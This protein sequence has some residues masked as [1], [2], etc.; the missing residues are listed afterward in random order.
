[1]LLEKPLNFR[2][3]KSTVVMIFLP[4]MIFVMR[5]FLH[6]I[7]MIGMHPSGYHNGH[8]FLPLSE[9]M[10]YSGENH[11]HMVPCNLPVRPSWSHLNHGGAEGW[12]D[13]IDT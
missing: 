13:L 12:K 2:A 5:P 7:P 3:P 6:I 4:Q 1:M 9:C 10:S 11:P 8:R